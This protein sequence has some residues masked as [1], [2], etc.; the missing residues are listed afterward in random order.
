VPMRWLSC[1][2]VAAVAAVASGACG[3][4]RSLGDGPGT[5]AAERALTTADDGSALPSGV[6]LTPWHEVVPGI[7]LRRGHAMTAFGADTVARPQDLTVLDVD[8]ATP[9][10]RFVTNPAG[11]PGAPPRPGHR[12]HTTGGALT[13]LA[14]AR[15]E[16]RFA[17]N[18]NFFWPCCSPRG[19]APVGMTLFGLAVEGGAVVA[20]PSEPQ[21]PGG[22]PPAPAV[23][24]G[25]SVGAPALLIDRANR[26][27]F[28]LVS[29]ADPVPPDTQVAV[30]GGPQPDGRTPPA[31]GAYDG[32]PPE[33]PVPGPPFLL[34][35]GQ[36]DTVALADPPESVAGRTFVGSSAGGRRLLVATIDGSDTGGAA[37]HD[38]AAWLGLLGAGDGLNLDG[39]GSSSLALNTAGL[40]PPPAVPCPQDGPVVLL[41]VPDN[42]GR[43][44][45]RLIGTYLGVVAPP[46]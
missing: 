33:R 38:E 24:D 1:L 10:L 21:R 27:S 34:R 41:D 43:C 16:V 36:T 7:R 37:F 32:Y 26:A 39:G 22:C 4:D 42:G 23:P 8:L 5:P 13:D 20:D 30:A 11:G 31:C 15:P 45:E 17:V 12:V 3:S 2:A 14:A 28:R 9:G 40:A 6:T 29:A 19:S 18:A 44:R 25:R 35:G 46:P